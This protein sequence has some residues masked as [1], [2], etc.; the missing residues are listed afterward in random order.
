MVYISKLFCSCRFIN[1]ANLDPKHD[2]NHDP[3]HDPNHDPNHD[4]DQNHHHT[5]NDALL[6]LIPNGT[7][8]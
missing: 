4:C 8:N 7:D 5:S 1:M 6:L 2:S 3:K